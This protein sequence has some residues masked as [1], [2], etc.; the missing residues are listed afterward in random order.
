[1]RSPT[2]R[3]THCPRSSDGSY[4][5]S[6]APAVPGGLHCGRLR[7]TIR[8]SAHRVLPPF[9]AGSIAARSRRSC[10]GSRTLA[11]LP[12]FTGGLHCG[13]A[14]RVDRS[15]DSAG[16]PAVRRRAPLRLA[17]P[18]RRADTGRT[19]SRRSPAGSIAACR[20]TPDRRCGCQVLPPFTGGLH[21]GAA[22]LR[23]CTAVARV[24]P[25]FS[26]GLH[27]GSRRGRDAV[28]PRLVLPPFTGGL[29]CGGAGRAVQLGTRRVLPPFNGGL[30]CGQRAR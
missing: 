28:R 6:R 1:M 23:T 29:H 17:V 7:V 21:C 15:L 12:P 27:C 13:T 16:A 14:Q 3:T 20:S 30:H 9:T 18:V 19:C 2:A 11:V 22:S 4:L 8:S 24:L 5:A 25:P 26:G 10:I